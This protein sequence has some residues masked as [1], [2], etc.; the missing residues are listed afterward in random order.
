MA[1]TSMIGPNDASQRQLGRLVEISRRREGIQLPVGFV[2][3]QA[4][5]PPAALII[6]GGRGGEVR[7]K[8]YF[9][10]TLLA[11]HPPYDITRMISSRTWAEMLALPDPEVHGARRVSDALNWLSAKQF[12]KVDRR[13]SMPP[14]VTLLSPLGDGSKYARPGQPY[15]TLPV[16]YWRRQWITVL[17]GTATVLYLILSDLTGGKKRSPKQSIR[18]G[19]RPRYGLSADSWTRAT[20]ELVDF[21]LI[22]VERAVR[23]KDLES[24]RARNLYS[25]NEERL[26]DPAPTL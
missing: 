24:V 23:G 19:D 5:P 1:K 12:I 8:L 20:A 22:N 26:D 25:V 10:L 11:A 14:V 13:P 15:V 16:G 6:R 18:P 7:L 3:S 17:S 9:C 21:G 2:R 4:P